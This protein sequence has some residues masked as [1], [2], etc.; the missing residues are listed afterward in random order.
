MTFVTALPSFG[1]TTFGETPMAVPPG[2]S[3]NLQVQTALGI[4]PGTY[5]LTLSSSGGGKSH[6]Q[7]VMVV[8]RDFSVGVTPA[9]QAILP[10]AEADYTVVMNSGSGFSADALFTCSIVGS[11][12]GASCAFDQPDLVAGGSTTARATT[13]AATPAGTYTINLTATSGVTIHSTS[14]TVQV[15]SPDFT[16]AP[17]SLALTVPLG[18]RG[19]ANITVTAL[20]GF[21]SPV[22]FTC[23]PSSLAL[24]CTAPAPIVPTTIGKAVPISLTASFSA[25]PGVYRLTFTATGGGHT[26]SIPITVTLE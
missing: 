6:S 21:S 16:L 3:F 19:T 13:A 10:G 24:S 8:V 22:S 23:G 4:V 15:G 20:Q 5:N 9:S 14:V 18:T 25:N 7:T 11:P 12:A 17:S 2:G 1:L 26:H